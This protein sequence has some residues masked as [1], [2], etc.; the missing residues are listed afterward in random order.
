MVVTSD[1]S[2]LWCGTMDNDKKLYGAFSCTAPIVDEEQEPQFE[3][4]RNSTVPFHVHQQLLTKSK[5]LNLRTVILRCLPFMNI[6][7]C[8]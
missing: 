4:N 8:C 6:S 3:S 5:S 7:H 2:A 1:S